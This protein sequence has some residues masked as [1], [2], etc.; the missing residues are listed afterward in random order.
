[1][2]KTLVIILLFLSILLFADLPYIEN[3]SPDSLATEIAVNTNIEFDLHDEDG[4][5]IDSVLVTIT[6][7]ANEDITHYAVIYDNLGV[8]QITD[9]FYEIQI[10]PNVNFR[11]GDSIFVNV[12]AMD[13]LQNELNV[14]Y[15][16]KCVEDD[17]SP[18]VQSLE[19]ANGE[20]GVLVNSS[21]YFD[22]KDSGGAGVNLSTIEV[23]V[24]GSVYNY[25]DVGVFSSFSIDYGYGITINPPNDF[26]FGATINLEISAEDLAIPPNT[27][28]ETSSFECDI[29]N[30][31]PTVED[32]LIQ[33]EEDVAIVVPFAQHSNDDQGLEILTYHISDY[34]ENGVYVNGSY[35]PTT[36]FNGIDVLTYRAFDGESFSDY[37][38]VNIIIIP[39]NDEP[40]A[41]A[42]FDQMVDELA[43]VQLDASASFDPDGD[44]ISY[45]WLMPEGIIL[46][47]ET[48]INP[49]FIAPAVVENEDFIF[50]LIVSDAEYNDMSNVTITV[51]NVNQPPIADAGENQSV[52]EGE[53]VYLNG[54]LSNDIDNDVLTYEWIAPPEIELFGSSFA[55]SYFIAPF[56]SEDIE[57]NFILTVNDGEYNSE[58][59]TIIVNVLNVMNHEPEIDIPEIFTFEEDTSF[60]QNFSY[61][62]DDLDNDDLTITVSGNSNIFVQINGYEITFSA[63]Q[64]WNG[65][66]ILTF[67]VNDNQGG[68]DVTDE[69]EVTVNPIN[70]PPILN[71]TGTFIFD[72]DSIL[73]TNF[74]QFMSQTYNETDNLILSAVGSENIDVAVLFNDVNF[75]PTADWFGTEEITFSLS[76]GEFT[77]NQTITIAVNSVND[78]PIINLPD[79]L[80]FDED[81]WYVGNFANYIDDVDTDILTLEVSENEEINVEINEFVVTFT[82]TAN[83]NGMETLT[84]T[85]NDNQNR[86][87]A[88][89]EIEVIVS[90]TN[91]APT[92][93]DLLL[94]TDE[95]IF[96]EVILLGN[97]IDGDALTIEVVGLPSNGIYA[98]GIYTPNTDFYGEDEFTYRAFDGEN[99]SNLAIIMITINPVNDAPIMNLPDNFTFD[100]DSWYVGNFANYIDDVDTDIL[101]LEVLGN[102]EINVEI[103]EF[104]VTF[105][106]TANWNGVENIIFS[107]NDNFDRTVVLDTVEVIVN[108]VEYPAKKVQVEPHTVSNNEC[109]IFIY[110]ANNEVIEHCEIL[111]RR[112][113][114]INTIDIEP[115]FNEYNNVARWDT[116]DKFGRQI[117]GGFYIYQVK[118]GE[119]TY[120]GSIIIV[121]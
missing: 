10:D 111:N 56:V 15:W 52:D 81:S 85:V 118:I 80:T 58:P 88:T 31:P 35:I 95:D 96:L 62:V 20:T 64:N 5:L 24:N 91:D 17:S 76:D 121:R 19:P 8:N 49:T 16:F 50:N 83:W 47:D 51:L 87:I 36:N 23:N 65:S 43:E 34:P 21:I 27:L 68:N 11:Y 60:Q 94:T 119:K 98:D 22:V 66:E 107:L 40:I 77:V 30:T 46:S 108:D 99:Y 48:A 112:G 37:A 4:I 89:D 70:D 105:T 113:K 44:E 45:L 86:T 74:T 32:F 55:E 13:I 25:L 53:T 103:N 110:T 59:D 2:K 104:V 92:V 72:E 84:F 3:L 61:F 78:A 120:Q 90:P 102:E 29:T 101:T 73:P 71:I 28:M 9:N 14:T 41:D 93:D 57:Y 109:E 63:S 106:A 67:A 100:E 39:R 115:A 79:N 12:R 54:S 75:E 114:I 1:M 18:F 7:N 6:E 97:D 116:T 38:T 69:V 33:T 42:G 82:A 26:N 117:P